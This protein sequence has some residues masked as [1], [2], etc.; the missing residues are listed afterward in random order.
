M[1][2]CVTWIHSKQ[3]P[4]GSVERGMSRSICLG[5]CPNPVWREFSVIQLVLPL[6][7]YNLNLPSLPLPPWIP[8]LCRW[9]SNPYGKSRLFQVAGS[10]RR[11][12]ERMVTRSG[13]DPY[14][15]K[16]KWRHQLHP[17]FPQS[18][19]TFCFIM[20]FT[21]LNL[22]TRITCWLSYKEYV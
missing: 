2:S 13:S 21:N 18:Q 6:H 11:K 1:H 17:F 5:R 20:A 3:L 22:P 15:V 16:R 4:K 12:G 9:Q 14:R 7:D 19:V 8:R 10:E